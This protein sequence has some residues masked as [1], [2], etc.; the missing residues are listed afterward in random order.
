MHDLLPVVR[1]RVSKTLAVLI[2]LNQA[3]RAAKFAFR[4]SPDFD[5]AFL[6][7]LFVKGR[8]LQSISLIDKTELLVKYVDKGRLEHPRQ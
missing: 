5:E 8:S 1:T 2:T 4:P 7:A 6:E 3:I